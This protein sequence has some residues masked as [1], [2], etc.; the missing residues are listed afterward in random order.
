VRAGMLGTDGGETRRRGLL[1][2]QFWSEK[3]SYTTLIYE[4]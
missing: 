1:Y 4:A 2:A 3:P